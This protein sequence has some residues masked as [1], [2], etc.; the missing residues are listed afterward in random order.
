VCCV[1]EVIRW[2]SKDYGVACLM[3]WETPRIS[4]KSFR[5][6][7]LHKIKS[8]G[9]LG[10]GKISALQRH[11]LKQNMPS[12]LAISTTRRERLNRKIHTD[13]LNECESVIVNKGDI[14]GRILTSV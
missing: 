10:V 4:C 6:Q 5:S 7:Q 8:K 11:S 12:K 2:W 3:K 13:S 1:E 14:D 9:K